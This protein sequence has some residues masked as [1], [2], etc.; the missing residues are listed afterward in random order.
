MYACICIYA[1]MC[2]YI[3]I[4]I[5]YTH[6]HRTLGSGASGWRG[7]GP[8][9]PEQP[10]GLALNIAQQQPYRSALYFSFREPV[11]I[12]FKQPVRFSLE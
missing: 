2:I 6:I 12:S 8:A 1:Y 11:V 3:Y 7:E 4:Y 5:Y 10:F 9:G